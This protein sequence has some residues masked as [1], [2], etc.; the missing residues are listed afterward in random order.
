MVKAIVTIIA[1]AFGLFRLWKQDSSNEKKIKQQDIFV[2]RAK[3]QQEVNEKDKDEKNI[4]L[5]VN[6][7]ND[8]EKEQGLNEIRKVVSK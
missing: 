6:S 8:Q 4:A 2:D 7:K 5:V 3:S 1:E